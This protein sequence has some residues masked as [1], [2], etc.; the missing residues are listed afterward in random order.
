MK[1]CRSATLVDIKADLCRGSAHLLLCFMQPQAVFAQLSM[2]QGSMLHQPMLT[3]MQYML[4][5]LCSP[6][7]HLSH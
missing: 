3:L 4:L 1:A 2:Q 7:G 5:C 6:S